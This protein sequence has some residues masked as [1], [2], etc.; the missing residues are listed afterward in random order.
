[1]PNT[2]DIGAIGNNTIAGAANSAI[3]TGLG[4]MLEHH[5][6]KRQLEQQQKLQ[7]MQIEGNKIM[8]QFNYDKQME[9]WNATNYGPQMKQLSE[10]GLNPGLIYGMGGGAGGTTAANTGQV[11]GAEAP[12][13]GQ[14]VLGMLMAQAQIANI[15]ANTQKTKAEIPNVGKTGEN[16]DAST[17]SLLQGVE[18]QKAQESLTKMETNLKEFQFDL[19]TEMRNHT[20]HQIQELSKKIHEEVGILETQNALD[21]KTADVKNAILHAELGNK[22]M[23]TFLKG[24][25]SQQISQEVVESGVRIQ[26]MF[27]DMAVSWE[28]LDLEQKR[29]NLQKSQQEWDQ[30][31]L[32]PMVKD[33]LNVIGGAIGITLGTGALKGMITPARPRVGY[34]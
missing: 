22:L 23:D 33:I 2:F 7:N 6:D 1:M 11:S 15:N 14:E 30:S 19:N 18:N 29:I 24:A 9:L 13:G 17:K 34:K 28:G 26:K 20:I 21:K 25:Q 31:G 16:I 32:P 12:K 8:G 27:N 10:A 5:N 3:G 4:L